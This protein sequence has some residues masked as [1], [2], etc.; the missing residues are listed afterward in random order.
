MTPALPRSARAVRCGL[1][2]V[3]GGGLAIGC[4][5]PATPRAVVGR[6]VRIAVDSATTLAGTLTMP[7]RAAASCAPAVLLLSGSGLQDREGARA[8]VPGYRPWRDVRDALIARGVAVLQLDD[9]GFGGS[10]GAFAGATT[11]D[12]ARDAG[13]ALRWLREV[14]GIDAWRLAV[15]GHSEGAVE[16]LL[17]AQADRQL[18]ALVLL[19]APSRPGREIARSQRQE[20][21]GSDLARWPARERRAVLAAAEA[22]AESL[23]VRDPRLRQW[24]ALDPRDVARGVRVP[25]LLLHGETD[26]QVPPRHADELA[27]VLRRSGAPVVAVRHL[28]QTNHLLLADRDGDPQGYGRLP[29]R[30]VRREALEALVGFLVTQLSETLPPA[31]GRASR[32][33]P[34]SLRENSC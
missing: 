34:A 33:K 4:V 19:G 16:A 26:R 29:D 9:R 20:L 17:V 23:A 25:V 1:I 15:V 28:P 12:F 14:P 24:F 30:R 5:E 10:T 13:T 11:A 22:V 2:A 8:D 27:D 31:K 6:E 18:A 3:V 21:V 7:V 32:E